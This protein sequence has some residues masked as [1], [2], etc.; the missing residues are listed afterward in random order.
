MGL[1]DILLHEY[2]ITFGINGSI[3]YI[4]KRTYLSLSHSLST[5]AALENTIQKVF[6]NAFGPSGPGWT[7]F[8]AVRSLGNVCCCVML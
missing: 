5:K 7:G 8:G 3:L 4:L 2:T 6:G 1:F